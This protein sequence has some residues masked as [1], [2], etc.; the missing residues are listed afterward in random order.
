MDYLWNILYTI[1]LLWAL[2]L[3]QKLKAVS[4]YKRVQCETDIPV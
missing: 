4:E 3:A 1:V 2:A